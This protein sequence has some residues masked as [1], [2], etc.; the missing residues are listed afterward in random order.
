MEHKVEE[1]KLKCGAKGLLIDTPDA[2]VFVMELWFR[3]G[4]SKVK[5][6][7]KFETAHIM[8]HMALGANAQHASKKDVD[9]YIDKYGA[10][11]NAWTGRDYLAYVR[12]CPDFDWERI[13]KQLVVQATTPKFLEKEFKAEFG[14]V[15]E[16]MRLRTNNHWDEIFQVMNQEFGFTYSDTWMQR[17]EKMQKVKLSDIREHYERTHGAKNL[18]FF[19]AGNLS[20][21]RDKILGILEGLDSLPDTERFK[22]SPYPK[23]KNYVKP[24]II[25]KTDVPNVYFNFEV[26]ATDGSLGQQ[27]LGANLAVLSKILGDGD[28]SRIYGKARQKGLVYSL[29]CSRGMS[30]NGEYEFY[31][32]AQVGH[33]NIN[34][35]IELIVVEY[36]K[37]IK[38]GLS[39]E[40]VAEAVESMKGGMRM[41]NQTASSI[42]HWYSGWYTAAEK[43]QL[44]HY[45][46]VDSWYDE[47]TPESI[48]ELFLNLIKTKKWGAG[49]L[50]NVTEK[51]AKKWNAKLA[52]IFED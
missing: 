12:V 44:L 45:E 2:P 48:Q 38:V 34:K 31:T 46:D 51:D 7:L 33:E 13:L 8:E 19:V 52:E 18:V 1:V 40:E 22:L 6:P 37:L 50:G 21:E 3:A 35:L 42:M 16:E 11:S 10:Y 47:V 14:N 25:K 39:K 24:V 5:N 28:H 23:I 41:D 27:Y 36:K 26:H 49:F 30:E 43:E 29:G 32:Y 17:L 4:D 20:K 15:E 9:R